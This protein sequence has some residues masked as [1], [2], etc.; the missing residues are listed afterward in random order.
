[1]HKLLSNFF[2]SI[3]DDKVSSLVLQGNTLVENAKAVEQLFDSA[4]KR[5]SLASDEELNDIFQNLE[6]GESTEVAHVN[7]DWANTPCAKRVFCDAMVQR[8]SD[9]VIFMEKKMASLLGL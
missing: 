5:R 3:A 9:A 8:G 4:R 6:R 7:G 1:M 2:V